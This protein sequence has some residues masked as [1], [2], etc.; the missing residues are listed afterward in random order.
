[1]RAG[2]RGAFGSK[3]LALQQVHIEIAVVVVVDERSAS[4]HHFR[5]VE[6]PARAVLVDER[7]TDA[8]SH[9]VEDRAIVSVLRCSERRQTRR[10]RALAIG[11]I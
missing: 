1:M 3:G 7:E 6:L 9:L 4:A 11:L 8:G 5:H 10:S 2:S